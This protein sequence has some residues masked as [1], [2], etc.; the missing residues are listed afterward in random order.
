MRFSDTRQT[1]TFFATRTAGGGSSRDQISNGGVLISRAA[2]RRGRPANS[3]W[4]DPILP[5]WDKVGTE[6]GNTVISSRLEILFGPPTKK[7]ILADR[8]TI[9]STAVG[10][11]KHPYFLAC[12]LRATVVGRK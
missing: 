7:E 8:S 1:A 12:D 3:A 5:C 4:G 6:W 10:K 11:I 2:P 9:G